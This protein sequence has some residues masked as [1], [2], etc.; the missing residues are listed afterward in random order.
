MDVNRLP[1]AM[2]MWNRAFL[3]LLRAAGLTGRPGWRTVLYVVL[4]FCLLT[5][6]ALAASWH[7]LSVGREELRVTGSWSRAAAV[8]G[9]FGVI[10]IEAGLAVIIALL[11]G[12]RSYTDALSRLSKILE[13]AGDLPQP[14]RSAI[15]QNLAALGLCV[16]VITLTIGYLGIN[17]VISGTIVACEMPTSTCVERA[18]EAVRFPF[19]MFVFLLIPLKFVFAGLLLTKGF[20]SVN[21]AIEV[22]ITDEPEAGKEHLKRIGELQKRFASCFLQLTAAMTYELI[23][24]MVYGVLT[25]ISLMMALINALNSSG[26]ITAIAVEIAL[27]LL[28]AAAAL[29]GPC[30][31][32]ER[33]LS[34]TGQRHDLLLEL[35]DRRPQLAGET[36][37]Q[38][39]AALRHLDT[40]GD[41]GLFRA[42][43]S[44]LL[45]ASATIGTYI[46]VIAQF[47]ASEDGG[48]CG[49]QLPGNASGVP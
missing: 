2:P 34:L 6:T 37:L 16:F 8:S 41:L 5:W 47:Q 31:T 42:R 45:A 9:F 40:F 28:S 24:S 23:L 25:E 1:H 18:V 38:R 44:T 20:Q 17:T 48:D 13:D 39:A 29:L 33:L 14:S 15:K 46:V 10:A 12:R 7:Q 49:R 19:L 11:T 43:R 32:C 36:G 4:L 21:S 22:M 26:Q 3:G 35:E 27:Y 30:E